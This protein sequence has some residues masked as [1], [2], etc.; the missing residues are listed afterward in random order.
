M[1]VTVDGGIQT[2]VVPHGSASKIGHTVCTTALIGSSAMKNLPWDIITSIKLFATGEGGRQGPTPAGS[3][4]CMMQIGELVFDIRMHLDQLGSLTPGQ[5]AVV[6]IS[7]LNPALAASYCSVGTRFV[8][9][10]ARPIGK[11]SIKETAL[12][13]TAR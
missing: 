4:S 9:R 1:T 10:E 7:F 13:R 12:L 5:E 6:P 2:V 11:G 3:F 8:L